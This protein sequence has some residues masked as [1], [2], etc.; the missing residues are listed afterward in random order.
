VTVA[1]QACFNRARN[2]VISGLGKRGPGSQAASGHVSCTAPLARVC[3]D[4][5]RARRG[6]GQQASRPW[7]ASNHVNDLLSQVREQGYRCCRRH[8]CSDGRRC[9]TTSLNPRRCQSG[10]NPLFCSLAV[11][12]VAVL[13]AWPRSVGEVPERSNGAVSKT[14]VPFAGDRGFE[15]LPLRQYIRYYNKLKGHYQNIPY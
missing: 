3:A 9:Q 5:R 15:S 12:R 8:Q 6:D 7:L 4:R 10:A 2:C 14:V 1:V 13:S 11:P